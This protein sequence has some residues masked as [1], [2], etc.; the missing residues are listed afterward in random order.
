MCR[1]ERYCRANF[2]PAEV[3][4]KSW[5]HGENLPSLADWSS[6]ADSG[7]I[8]WPDRCR[9]HLT[10]LNSTLDAQEF[11]DKQDLMGHEMRAAAW[12]FFETHCS[13]RLEADDE[14]K[15]PLSFRGYLRTYTLCGISNGW[16][17]C[18]GVASNV[19]DPIQ[20]AY[21]YRFER[22][23]Q[24]MVQQ[25]RPPLGFDNEDMHGAAHVASE[26]GTV[27]V[28]AF[29]WTCIGPKICTLKVVPIGTMPS[30][31][32]PEAARARRLHHSATQ[33]ELRGNFLF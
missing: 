15:V 9:I 2:S 22:Y 19:Q 13:F 31:V 24:W 26:S 18:K 30:V 10:P 3:A 23:N 16:P 33:E 25:S 8:N 17:V 7:A 21:L 32:P 5:H 4:R 6:G 20:L 11:K 14:M 29:E 27:P 1:A 12:E 28:G